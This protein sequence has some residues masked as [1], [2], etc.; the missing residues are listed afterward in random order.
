MA[1]H[2][3]WSKIKRQK[4]KTDAQ[5]SKIFSKLA[6]AISTAVKEARG[7]KNSPSVRAVV[8]KAREF[9]MPLENIERAI[10]KSSE[11][12]AMESVTYEAYGPGGCALII[13]ALTTNRNKAAQEVK[14]ILSESGF[15]LAAPGSASWA[16]TKEHNEWKPNMAVPISEEDGKMLEDLI[17][18]LEENDEVQD[19][20]T[21]AE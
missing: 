15:E 17:E 8:D 16:F 19:V 2:N 6:K 20:Y 11:A 13:E 12:G 3:K 18:K 14:H 4:E 10:K 9:N 21:N 5:K 7:D 1:G